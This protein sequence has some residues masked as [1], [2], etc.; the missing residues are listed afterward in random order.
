VYKIDFLFDFQFSKVDKI[1]LFYKFSFLKN[2]HWLLIFSI[3]RRIISRLYDSSVRSI[4]SGCT[5]RIST[6]ALANPSRP[7]S[8]Y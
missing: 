7:A 3:R 4:P 1:N 2:R 8:S 6:S 5:S